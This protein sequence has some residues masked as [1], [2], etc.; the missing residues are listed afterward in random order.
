[1]MK[2]TNNPLRRQFVA[3]TTVLAAMAFIQG[4]SSVIQAKPVL[5][6]PNSLPNQLPKTIVGKDMAE[7]LWAEVLTEHVDKEG[8]VNFAGIAQNPAK[9]EQVVAFIEYVSPQ[10]RPDLY[11]TPQSE[12]AYHI[13]T[14]NALAMYAVVQEGIPQALRYSRFTFMFYKFFFLNKVVIGGRKMSLYAYENEV[15]RALGEP[16]IHFALN[17]MSIGCPRLP[18]VP[19]D[20][21]VLDKQ[22]DTEAKIFFAEERNVRLNPANRTVE[23]SEILKFYTE[24][25]LRV[26]TSLTS[27]VNRYRDMP[28]P[29][30]YE[31]KFQVYDWTVNR[32]PEKKSSQ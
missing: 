1:M 12:L 13:N 20:P 22:L 4:C 24:D 3:K 29:V 30:D 10:S 28:I 19:F 26:S 6:L 31:V 7:A 2:P 15:I 16:R 8:R 27:Y 18:Q 25:F 32:W 5:P 11:P 17:C 14:Y 21:K 9:L 23:L